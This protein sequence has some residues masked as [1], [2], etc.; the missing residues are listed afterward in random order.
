MFSPAIER[1]LHTSLAAHEGQSRKRIPG[2][3]EIPYIVHP[4]HVALMLAR[5][6][7][8]EDVIVAGL[9]HDVVEDCEGWTEERVAAEFGVHVASIVEQ[10]TED[11]SLTWD[12]RKRWAIDH[13]PHMSPEAASVKAVDKLHNLHS[14]LADLRESP[15]PDAVWAK[16]KGGRDKT[17]AH[18]REFV[19]ALSARVDPR[20]ARALRSTLKSL[21]EQVERGTPRPRVQPQP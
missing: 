15:D 19:E 20:I 10:L 21:L 5:F 1:A 16:F 4:M 12:E 17:L 8:E 3:P 14:L 11:K 2:R 18:D 9:L 13:V 6:G 7:M